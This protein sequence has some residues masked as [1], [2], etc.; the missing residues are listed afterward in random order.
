M[1]HEIKEQ[2]TQTSCCNENC[3]FSKFSDW[4]KPRATALVLSAVEFGKTNRLLFVRSNADLYKAFLKGFNTSELTQ[5]HTCNTCERYLNGMATYGIINPEFNKVNAFALPEIDSEFERMVPES[6][7]SAYAEVVKAFNNGGWDIPLKADI[8]N[9][10]DFFGTETT[11]GWKHFA[12]KYSEIKRAT[13]TKL[14]ETHFADPKNTG[15]SRAELTVAHDWL[16]T[17][18]KNVGKAFPTD[19]L[20]IKDREVFDRINEFAQLAQDCDRGLLLRADMIINGINFIRTRNTVVGKLIEDMANGLPLEKILKSYNKFIDPRCYMRPTRMPSEGKFEQD[21]KLLTEKGYDVYMPM[22]LATIEDLRERNMLNW[23]KAKPVE[24]VED[25]SVKVDIFKKQR[26]K[27]KG[28]MSDAKKTYASVGKENVSM[29]YLVN[30]ILSKSELIEEI[31]FAPRTFNWG[32]FA[33]S[34]VTDGNNLFEDGNPIRQFISASQIYDYDASRYYSLLNDDKFKVDAYRLSTDQSSGET[35]ANFI[36]TNCKWNIGL[37]PPLFAQTLAVDIRDCRA[38]IEQYMKSNPVN[39]DDEGNVI[40]YE[41][42]LLV[43]P[44]LINHTVIINGT[45]GMSREYVITGLK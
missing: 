21:V 38:T 26:D 28:I 39:V 3:D 29:R 14:F 36:F 35:V 8:V 11:G 31:Y 1:L 18:L 15:L 37:M 41:T 19:K 32:S 23:E 22:R 13:I 30:E 9:Y 10:G 6:Y 16:N 33:I 25:K 42:T 40:E 34:H 27:M 17:I 44:C 7:H 2:S 45:D 20:R 43:I 4:F 5:E 12:I 24:V